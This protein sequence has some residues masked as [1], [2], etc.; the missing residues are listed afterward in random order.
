MNSAQQP[1]FS[2]TSPKDAV[3]RPYL[4]TG[5]CR[6][7]CCARLSDDMPHGGVGAARKTARQEDRPNFGR[8][9][10][11]QAA[12]LRVPAGCWAQGARRNCAL[13]RYSVSL[14][15]AYAWAPTTH[16]SEGHQ[17][18]HHTPS[19]TNSKST[20]TEHGWDGS[21]ELLFGW[22]V[23]VVNVFLCG[24]GG[25]TAC[26]PTPTCSHVPSPTACACHM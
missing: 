15:G 3:L 5:D 21:P 7:R 25:C 23:G 10:Y 1:Q 9:R 13:R 12:P 18:P 4:I 19:Q 11:S 17:R 26:T 22:G 14:A 2:T 20:R 24:Y 8:S 6:R 16:T